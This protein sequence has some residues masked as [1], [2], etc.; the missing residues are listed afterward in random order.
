MSAASDSALAVRPC[1]DSLSHAAV[2]RLASASETAESRS[3]VRSSSA[4]PSAETR[5]RC[6]CTR[7]TA[8]SIVRRERSSNARAVSA[9]VAPT[10]APPSAA[11]PTSQAP[12]P[13][14][15]MPTGPPMMMPRP[16]PAATP[17]QPAWVAHRL[18][19]A[20][21][22]WARVSWP[23]WN[24]SA[25]ASFLRAAYSS[26]CASECTSSTSI[27]A[28]ALISIAP[29]SHWRHILAS[30]SAA[31]SWNTTCR[32]RASASSCGT[33]ETDE[34]GA[35]GTRTRESDL[36]RSRHASSALLML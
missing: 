10:A 25:V 18:T 23:S 31:V 26:F 34:L 29:C 5:A 8:S 12:T 27:S 14:S 30:S 33:H 2:A 9:P 7:R 36:Y 1:A 28:S 15:A 22:A 17:V 16:T 21:C 13:P 11:P 6:S 4:R 35:S 19:R 32:R 3:L 20:R 24:W